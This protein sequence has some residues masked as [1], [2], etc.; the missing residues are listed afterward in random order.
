M[1]SAHLKG[2]AT[3]QNTGG[4]MWGSDEGKNVSYWQAS[5]DGL[6]NDSLGK[7]TET[8]VCVI[9]GGIAGLTTAYLLARAGRQVLVIDDGPIGG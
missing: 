7:S 5:A 2:I 1:R 6:R 8:E 9:G 3:I 4:V